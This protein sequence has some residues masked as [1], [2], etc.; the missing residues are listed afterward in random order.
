[1]V[2]LPTQLRMFDY[3][4]IFKHD[5]QQMKEE[6]KNELNGEETKKYKL[7]ETKNYN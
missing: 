6:F 1:M 2:K 4:K 5:N 3:K 7:K